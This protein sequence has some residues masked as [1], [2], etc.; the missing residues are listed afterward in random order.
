MSKDFKRS[1]PTTVTFDWPPYPKPE[2]DFSADKTVAAPGQEIH[3]VNKSSEV[4]EEWEWQF[5]GGTPAVSHEENP[6]VTYDKEG[7]YS[8]T[9]VAK[10][11]EGE[12]VLTKKEMITI[13]EAAKDIQNVALNKTTIASGQCS[14]TEAAKF[15]FD[16]K[17]TDNSKWCALGTPPH[18]LQ[19]DLG[20]Q[21]AISKFVI[22]HAEAGGEPQAFNTQAFRIEV[23][24]DGEN[25]TEV[26]K[27]TDNT[28]AVSEHSITLTNARYARLLV[29]KPTQGGDTAARIYEFEVYGYP[30][31]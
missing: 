13:S 31:P 9:L 12:S 6:V 23:S 20:G 2:A 11:S 15:A 26:V 16:G 17:V 27:V 5:E 19:V 4:T 28:A 1:E 3:F 18:W 22:R 21:Y 10:N 7:V 24:T 29:D 14:P 30:N 25:W 8:V